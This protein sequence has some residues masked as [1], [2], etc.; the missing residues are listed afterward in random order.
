MGIF[1]QNIDLYWLDNLDC[2]LAL[3]T[4][5]FFFSEIRDK[6]LIKCKYNV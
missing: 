3:N 4:I 2:G 6:I 5:G 1:I